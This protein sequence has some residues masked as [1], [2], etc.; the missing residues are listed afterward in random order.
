MH[1]EGLI[2]FA[3]NYNPVI[4]GAHLFGVVLGF[5]AALIGDILFFK[6]LKDSKIE[7]KEVDVLKTM[8]KIVW[9]GL[10]IIVI[11]GVFL[12]LSDVERYS[13]SSKFLVKMIVV[14]IIILNGGVLNLAVAPKLTSINFSEPRGSG[15]RSLAFACGAISVT[16]WWT[17]F[18]LGLMHMSPAPFHVLL[19][20]YLFILA[21]AILI[22]QILERLISTHKINP[23]V[24]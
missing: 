13:Q 4:V 2:F 11:S 20:I 6:F 7:E 10:F 22:S 12:F 3:Q 24:V 18:I 14:G 5:G 23:P 16:S 21:G 9:T 8:S 15:I 1:V 17:A 19:S